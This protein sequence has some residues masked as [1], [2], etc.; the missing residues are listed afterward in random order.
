[1]KLNFD[2]NLIST[3]KLHKAYHQTEYIWH[4]NLTKPK[5]KRIF[6][7][8]FKKRDGDEKRPEGFYE[9]YTEWNKIVWYKASD[10]DIQRSQNIIKTVNGVNQ[11][12]RGAIVEI[13]LVSEQTI[14]RYF[15]SDEEAEEWII[16][17]KSMT[18]PTKTFETIIL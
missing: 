1:M 8:L 11:L 18:S 14:N 15:S 5:Y 3:I 12:W 13:T 4:S 6:L 7:G 17:L 2:V 9:A 10:R 16:L